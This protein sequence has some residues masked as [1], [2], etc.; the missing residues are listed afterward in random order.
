MKKENILYKKIVKKI[1]YLFILH[2]N[3]S[4]GKINKIIKFVDKYIQLNKLE[5]IFSVEMESRTKKIEYKVKKEV[6]D[7]LSNIYSKIELALNSVSLN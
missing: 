3:M 4:L 6:K 7:S 2:N 5:K 1:S